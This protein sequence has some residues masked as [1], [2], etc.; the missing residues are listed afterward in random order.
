M[1]RS[2]P[3]GCTASIDPS[4]VTKV[5]ITRQIPGMYPKAYRWVAEMEEIG[6]FLTAA[7]HPDAGAMFTNGA[8]P[9]YARIAQDH[10]GGRTGEIALLDQLYAP[11]DKS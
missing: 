2:Q 6:R 4:G 5:G 10:A 8:A 11:M 1:P 7:G 3:S 9:L